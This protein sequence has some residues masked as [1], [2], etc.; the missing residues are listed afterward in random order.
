MTRIAI[1]M[2]LFLALQPI[3]RAADNK[4]LW[5]DA[6]QKYD[7]GDYKGAVETYSRLAERGFISAELYYNLGNSYFKSGSLGASIWAYR[8]ALR[9]DPGMTKAK[10]NL[11]YVREFNVDKIIVKRSGFVADIWEFSTGLLSSNGYMIVFSAVWWILGFLLFY[12][13]LKPNTGFWTQYLLI[14]VVIVAIFTGAASVT[15]VR[16]DRLIRWGVLTSPSA[17]IREGPGEDF[18]KIEVGHEGLEFRI[19]AERENSYLIELNN[20]LK[21]WVIADAVLEI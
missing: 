15:R 14:L 18:E 17:E 2:A 4:A 19:L 3:A 6:A 21:G 9:I 13:I 11:Q 16:N 1:S 5:D 10:T 12:L 7:S 20:G 8:K